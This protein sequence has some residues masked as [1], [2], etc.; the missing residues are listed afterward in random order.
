M[1][2]VIVQ[3]FIASSIP[4]LKVILLCS[5]GALAARVV[6]WPLTHKTP[7]RAHLLLELCA[8]IGPFLMLLL[9]ACT[10]NRA[11]SMQTGRRRYRLLPFLS[12][13]HA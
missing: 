6:S 8:L 3:L 7:S 2:N 9:W 12:L 13:A 1:T 10:R 11:Y 4:V 5:V